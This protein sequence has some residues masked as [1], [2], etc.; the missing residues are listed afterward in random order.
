LP[1]TYGSSGSCSNIGP[2]Y[3]MTSGTGTCTVTAT[4]PGNNNYQAA[5]PV[6]ENTTAE[7]AN[8]TVSFTG[9]PAEAPYNSQFV[10]LA[11]TNAS[12][13]AYITSSNPTTCSLSGPYSPV[14]VTML[15]DS[16]KCTFTAS[17][18]AYHN[19]NPAT[20]TQKTTAEKA[21]PVITWATPAAITYGTAL[22]ATQLDASA[23]VAGN[24]V[25]SPAAGKIEPAGSNTLKVTFT[26]SN[27]NYS[28]TTDTVMLQVSQ[29]ATV[30][31]ITSPSGTITLSKKGTAT[32]VLKFNVTSYEPTGSV[33]LTASTGETCSGT[34][35]AA[36][37]DGD[38][39]LTF[40]TTGTRT[41][42]ATYG[43]DA[44]HTGSNNSGQNPPVTV[45]VNPY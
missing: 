10:M 3:T 5:S 39:K 28:K 23:N 18:G 21:T 26:P 34:L 35:I 9:A 6:S 7:R 27:A 11:S 32:T 17:W 37:G 43:G 20:A 44:N 41:I 24:F 15:K 45:T 14:T 1:I 2:V 16:G 25:Y 31:T 40:S 33:A 30:T 36:T 22:S 13:V 19:Y 29:A 38:C 12:T 42:T 4:Q 8:Q